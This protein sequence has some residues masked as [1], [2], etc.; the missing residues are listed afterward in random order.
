VVE[1]SFVHAKQ[2][3]EEDMC[4]LELSGARCVGTRGCTLWNHMAQEAPS[5]VKCVLP[6][7]VNPSEHVQVGRSH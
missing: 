4:M 6:L 3:C 5:S 2:L 7:S 1:A